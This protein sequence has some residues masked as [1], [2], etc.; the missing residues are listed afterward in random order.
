MIEIWRLTKSETIE[1]AFSGEHAKIYGGRWNKKDTRVVYCAGTQSL[2]VLE[3]LVHLDRDILPKLYA[4]KISVP[5]GITI[6]PLKEELPRNWRDIPAP[7]SLQEIGTRW[8]TSGKNCLLRVP[9][10]VIPH[11]WNYLINPL[12][13]DF[14][15]LRIDSPG[16]FVLDARLISRL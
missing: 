12:H 14:S 4:Y 16:L 13:K 1:E 10:A 7:Q 2:C 15:K 5:K 8:I 3:V 9:S 6:E 11:E